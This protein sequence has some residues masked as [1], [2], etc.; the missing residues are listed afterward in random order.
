MEYQRMEPLLAAR[1]INRGYRSRNG[2]RLYDFLRI[3]GG[4]WYHQD[5]R[6]PHFSLTMERGPK[7]GTANSF[8]CDHDLILK[9]Y[10]KFADLAALHGSDI[11]G[12][13]MYAA[14]NGWCS[15]AGA[16]P[17]QAGAKYTA[18]TSRRHYPKPEGA[19][20]CGSRDNTDYRNPT[21]DECLEIFARHARVTV[22]T[23][24][25]LRGKLVT[26]WT[27]TREASEFDNRNVEFMHWTAASWSQASTYFNSWIEDQRPRWKQEAEACIQHH[28]LKLYGDPWTADADTE[29]ETIKA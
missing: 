16:L 9:Y 21:P 11:D 2:A 27:D 6:K 22:D 24:R 4:L 7:G 17:N 15:L 12:A 13:P 18:A 8:G 28:G 23:A 26:I 3:V 14:E 29:S 19:P 20:R 25:E 10:P 5:N 1:I